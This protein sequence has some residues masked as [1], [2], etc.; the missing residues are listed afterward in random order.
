MSL[1]NYYIVD[2]SIL[3]FLQERQKQ[4][5]SL[6]TSKDNSVLCEDD[7]GIDSMN[8]AD[9]GAAGESQEKSK[10]EKEVESL[11]GVTNDILGTNISEK[12]LH[13]D[14]VEPEKLEWMKELPIVKTSGVGL[15]PK[16][17]ISFV[18]YPIIWDLLCWIISHL[19]HFILK[20]AI[21]FYSLF[22][23]KRA[24]KIRL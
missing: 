20:Q 12:W 7:E 2:P 14:Q 8:L 19:F 11:A 18:I 23:V 4:Q 24:S 15:G 21:F 16:S 5:K 3:K 9:D 1:S 6:I 22:T 13:M 17:L 10:S